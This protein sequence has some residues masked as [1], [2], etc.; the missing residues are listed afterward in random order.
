[1]I[2]D[3]L[4]I[5][6]LPQLYLTKKYFFS[7]IRREH[8]VTTLYKID[9]PGLQPRGT[10]K[11]L[12]AVVYYKCY[13]LRH[14]LYDFGRWHIQTG[15]RSEGLELWRPTC[16]VCSTPR[17][18]EEMATDATAAREART[19]KIRQAATSAQKRVSFWSNKRRVMPSHLCQVIKGP[20][21]DTSRQRFG[22][23]GL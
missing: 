12:S 4:D 15:Y 7:L 13:L 23:N 3:F 6:S 22:T 5:V 16:L 18:L 1:M 20:V 17:S 9:D 11:P 8:I 19:A 14:A 21:V 10:G 2:I